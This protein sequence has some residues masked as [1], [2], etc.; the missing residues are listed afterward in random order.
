MPK[1][2]KTFCLTCDSETNQKVLFSKIEKSKYDEED[3]TIPETKYEDNFMTVQCAGCNTLSF[4][5]RTTITV[6][7]EGDEEPFSFDEYYPGS[8]SDFNF[9]N[10]DEYHMLPSMLRKVYIEIESAFFSD[11]EILAGLGLRTL[12]EAI[13]MEQKVNGNNLQQK[14]LH[15]KDKGLISTNEVPILDKLRLIGNVA[16]HQIKGLPLDIL[17]YA[18]DIVNHVLKSIYILPKINKKIK[19]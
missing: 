10:D 15:L 11:S 17:S 14:I 8:D 13:C 7:G 19:L 6:T 3:K 2:I 4:V 12:V 16:A 18:L 1:S 9:L 5:K